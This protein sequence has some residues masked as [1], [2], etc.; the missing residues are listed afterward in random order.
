MYEN[1]CMKSLT[2]QKLSKDM[3]KKKQN[4]S[5]CAVKSLGNKKQSKNKTVKKK[6]K[7]L[8]NALKQNEE[9]DNRTIHTLERLMKIKKNKKPKVFAQ[10][11]LDYILDVV[12]GGLNMDISSDELS[13]SDEACENE[14]NNQNND[15]KSEFCT[16]ADEMS[17]D[18]VSCS[19]DKSS[20][21]DSA[22]NQTLTLSE[23]QDKGQQKKCVR[24]NINN[25]QKSNIEK[26][27]HK[28][29][30][31]N[32]TDTKSKTD[33]IVSTT[34]DLAAKYV[35]PANRTESNDAE[36]KLERIRRQMKGLLN[37]LSE[38][39]MKSICSEIESFYSANSRARVTQNLSDV[40]LVQFYTPDPIP[41]K[42]VT[43][44]A[45]L[46]AVLS[47][48]IGTEVV[49]HFL[50]VTVKKLNSLLQFP[51]YGTGKECNNIVQFISSLYQM[52]VIQKQIILDII[53][54]FCK[55]FNERDVELMLFLLKS[56][57][58]QLRK[59]DPVSLKSIV[60]K[61]T[62]KSADPGSEQTSR[63][64]FML[65]VVT[66]IK[67]NNVRKVLDYDFDLVINRRK[68][69]KAFCVKQSEPF[70]DVGFLDLV[71][72]DDKGRWWVVGSSW[73]GA[74]MLRPKTE[75]DKLESSVSEKVKKAAR[76]LR[77][78]T[79]VR[80]RIFYAAMSGDDFVEAF[81]SV[82]NLGLK[83]KQLREVSYVLTK[84]CQEEKT[85]NPF[86]FHLLNKFCHHDRQFVMSLQCAFWDR[87]KSLPSLSDRNLINISKLLSSLFISEALPL[88]CLKTFDYAE[89]DKCG[90]L[91]LRKV[92]SNIATDVKSIVEIDHIFAKLD[93]T[94]HSLVRNGLRLF[95][96]HFMLKDS[97]F[98]KENANI[99]E[100]LLRMDKQ[101]DCK[102][103]SFAYNSIF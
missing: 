79:D 27:P 18:E 70:T 94:K 86:Y 73:G 63:M 31:E 66:A 12:D 10:D 24:F 11:G 7:K 15:F 41:E 75:E 71:N 97:S 98:I 59:D 44:S 19:L 53:D 1:N 33:K 46:I 89:I 55:S 20:D 3:K 100:A 45:M 4:T 50:E 76:K 21:N 54:V 93:P 57:G 61:V 49:G 95:I 17:E 34:T 81:N 39:N 84:C 64:K 77:M 88:S 48:N 32:C 37:R 58:F 80:R 60:E 43:E 42:L 74:P 68:K 14:R 16:D 90:V 30:I 72:A 9:D 78:N 96:Q 87:F 22:N 83:G 35:P 99:E 102:R 40:V 38:A 67:N 23:I 62:L 5:A 56:T 6:Q 36:K 69:I 47:H 8:K 91:F 103:Q 52:K 51:N 28:S 85:F 26:T 101:L 13:I 25:F 2:R 65:D 92:F 82:M 29:L